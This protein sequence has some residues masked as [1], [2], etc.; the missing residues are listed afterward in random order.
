MYPKVSFFKPKL[1]LR[2]CLTMRLILLFL[3]LHWNGS[4]Y[5]L[6]QNN[7]SIFLTPS[8]CDVMDSPNSLTCMNICNNNLFT[9]QPN[10]KQRST[11]AHTKLNT[12]NS[13]LKHPGQAVKIIT[14]SA[15]GRRRTF[16]H[17]EVDYNEVVCKDAEALKESK[18]CT[19]FN[20]F[21]TPGRLNRTNTKLKECKSCDENLIKF[22]FTKHGIEVISDVETIV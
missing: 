17:A 14:E 8:P 9:H 4:K 5:F 13:Q 6:Q 20:A 15:S 2:K 1:Y 19:Y 10:D 18:S 3:C 16:V 22:I 7:S 11:D 21:E 12:I